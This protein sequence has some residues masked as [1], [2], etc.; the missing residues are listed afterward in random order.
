MPRI[1]NR[2]I[3]AAEYIKDRNGSAAAVRAGYSEKS[4]KIAA[5]KLLK[6]KLVVDEINRLQKER[7]ERLKIDADYVLTR[8][9]QIDEMDALDILNDN[10]SIK[11]VKEWPKIWRQFI[12]GID[13]VELA[14]GDTIGIVKKIKWPDKVKNLELIGKHVDVQAF[15][16]SFKMEVEGGLADRLARARERAKK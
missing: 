14:S 2:L 13:V 4:A 3:F 9:V 11:P 8:L 5:C 7:N 1:D 16:E 12:S 6:D 15:K 10:G